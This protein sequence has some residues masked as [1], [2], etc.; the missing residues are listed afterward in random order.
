M[1]NKFSI[2]KDT[3]GR[4][5]KSPIR[6]Q[7]GNAHA[8]SNAPAYET[9]TFGFVET[10]VE[11]RIVE[12]T[13]CSEITSKAEKGFGVISNSVEQIGNDSSETAWM[14]MA[15]DNPENRKQ[16]LASKHSQTMQEEQLVVIKADT[17]GGSGSDKHHKKMA[18]STYAYQAA[19]GGL[20]GSESK[21]ISKYDSGVVPGLHTIIN[22]NSYLIDALEGNAS[23]A[24]KVAVPCENEFGINDKSLI[25][26]KQTVKEDIYESN[27]DASDMSS[28]SMLTLVHGDETRIE[29]NPQSHQRAEALESLLE[30]CSNL[31]KQ[32][33]FD[34]LAGLLRPFGEEFVSSRETAIWLTQ[35]LMNLRKA[36]NGA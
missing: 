24:S 7:V 11:T 2:G 27:G 26:S 29:L 22:P 4:K 14:H 15:T 17:M 16:E 32:E 28:M 6:V 30:I 23:L 20:S 9:H 1:S 33:K 19:S 10:E 3:Q 35:S 36:G 21:K 31:L 5:A 18:T 12:T 34:E 8:F 25:S 13:S